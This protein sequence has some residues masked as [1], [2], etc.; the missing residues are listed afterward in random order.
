MMIDLVLVY[1]LRYFLLQLI[2]LFRATEM[3]PPP[4]VT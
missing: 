2:Q 4:P 3:T 1:F